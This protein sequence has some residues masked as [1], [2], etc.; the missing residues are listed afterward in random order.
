MRHTLAALLNTVTATEPK[1]YVIA[2]PD[3]I[4]RFGG[5]DCYCREAVGLLFVLPTPDGSRVQIKGLVRNIETMD[6]RV[7][8]EG[9]YQLVIEAVDDFAR[10]LDCAKE[11]L[12]FEG[13]VLLPR[14]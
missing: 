4:P 11:H 12:V 5:T 7:R 14:D 6:L 9:P 8:H 3:P 13:P 10:A 1:V 2:A